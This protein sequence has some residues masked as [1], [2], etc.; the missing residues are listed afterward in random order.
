MFLQLLYGVGL[1][2]RSF[3]EMR[4]MQSRL[5]ISGAAHQ[6]VEECNE[7]LNQW[8]LPY[9]SLFESSF[10]NDFQD[11]SSAKLYEEWKQHLLQLVPS[12][13]KFLRETSWLSDINLVVSDWY[14]I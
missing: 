6:V 1:D 12:H 11:Q 10:S 3:H 8:E 14:D 5:Q 9:L 7:L 13:L 2:G 4:S